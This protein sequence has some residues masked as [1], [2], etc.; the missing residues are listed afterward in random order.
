MNATILF[1]PAIAGTETGADFFTLPLGS[2]IP[3]LQ[4]DSPNLASLQLKQNFERG[5][6]LRLREA[7]FLHPP[8]QHL[9]SF[10]RRLLAS[11]IQTLQSGKR[12]LRLLLMKAVCSAYVSSS[13]K[14]TIFSA[15]FQRTISSATKSFLCFKQS[16]MKTWSCLQPWRDM[17]L[18]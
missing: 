16:H 6:S 2:Q 18:T 14:L 8:P 11:S 10:S 9:K 1:A 3:T 17:L 5:N 13:N 7:I 12:P 4:V 15:L